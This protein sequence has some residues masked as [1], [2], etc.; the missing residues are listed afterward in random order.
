MRKNM[1][2]TTLCFVFGH[3]ILSTMVSSCHCGDDTHHR[4]SSQQYYFSVIDYKM[5]SEAMDACDVS[6]DNTIFNSSVLNVQLHIFG[7][8]RLG[9]LEP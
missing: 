1:H 6:F 4:N 9:S 8:Q 7:G 3:V 5:L 2:F